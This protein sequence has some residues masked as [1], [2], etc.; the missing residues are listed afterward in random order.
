MADSRSDSS[1]ALRLGW[2]PLGT[3]RA[4]EAA[5]DR[6]LAARLDAAGVVEAAY[7]AARAHHPALPTAMLVEA[8]AAV[9]AARHGPER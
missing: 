9:L 3:L 4:M 8:A 5:K 6:A 2:L 1:A 7:L